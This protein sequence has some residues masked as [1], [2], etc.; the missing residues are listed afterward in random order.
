MSARSADTD[1]PDLLEAVARCLRSGASLAAALRVAANE[2]RATV[3]EEVLAVLAA[4]D[5]GVRLTDAFEE[6]AQQSPSRARRLVAA[7]VVVAH[8]VGGGAAQTFDAVATSLR[9]R[10]DAHRDANVMAAQARASAL[11]IGAAPM[12]FAMMVASVDAGVVRTVV[13]SPLGIGSLVAGAGLEALG[14]WWIARLVRGPS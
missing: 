5:H 13:G 7:A 14:L 1:L 10:A 2:Y 3:G 12:A 9:T 4:T 6:W 11:V 8:D